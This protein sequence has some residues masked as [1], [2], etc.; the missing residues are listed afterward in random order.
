MLARALVHGAKDSGHNHSSSSPGGRLSLN[1]QLIRTTAGRSILPART[2]EVVE[3]LCNAS[4]DHMRRLEQHRETTNENVNQL[5]L[6]RTSNKDALAA[7]VIALLILSG[8]IGL[9]RNAIGGVWLW[10]WQ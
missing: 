7:L 1:R 9:I 3:Y 2:E 4:N 5:A 6:A 8:L 10:I